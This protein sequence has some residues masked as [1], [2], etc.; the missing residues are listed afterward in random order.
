[1][2]RTFDGVISKKEQ[3]EIRDFISTILVLPE[4]DRAILM[5]YAKAYKVR[6][7]VEEENKRKDRG[8]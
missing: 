5:T 3:Q 8:A 2:K 6:M 7:E 1:M 4:S